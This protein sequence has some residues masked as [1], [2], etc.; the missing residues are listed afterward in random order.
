MDS[1]IS[2]N[3]VGVRI[4]SLSPSVREGLEKESSKDDFFSEGDKPI[5][6]G[7]FGQVWKVRHKTTGQIYVIKVMIKQNIIEQKMVGQINREVE[8]M[9]KIN[10]PHIIKLINHF[11]DDDYLY[12]IM[13]YASKGQ[14]YSLLK[15]QGRFDQRNAAQYMREV[16]S[17]VKYLHSFDPPIIHRDIK[18][19]NILLDENGRV[20]LADFGWSN[21]ANTNELR[22]TYCGTPEYLAPEMIRKEGHDT[23]IDI[24]DLGV[25]LFELLCGKPPFA[26]TSQNELFTNIKK[27]RINW[28]DDFPPLAKN[29]ISKILKQNPKERLTLDEILSHSWFDK[30][31]EI[32]PVLVCQ[33]IDER[34]WLES[35]MINLKNEKTK[36]EIN[37]ILNSKRKSIME[38]IRKMS[39]QNQKASQ[40]NTD[41]NPLRGDNNNSAVITQLNEQIEKLKKEN[42]D[43]KQKN[44][45]N[46]LKL[47]TLKNELSKIKDPSVKAQEEQKLQCL[48]DELDKYKRMNKDRLGFL[49]EIKEKGKEIMELKKK[50]QACE[51]DL[52][53]SKI[54]NLGLQKKYNE[55][56]AQNELLDVKLNGLKKQLDE[57]FKEKDEEITQYRKKYE[58]LKQKLLN[59]SSTEED[60]QFKSHT[61]LEMINESISEYKELFVKKTENLCT[62]LSDNKDNS[63]KLQTE[64]VN[65]LENKHQKVLETIKKTKSVLEQNFIQISANDKECSSKVNERLEWQKKQISAL[66][67]FK[68]KSINLETQVSKYEQTIK[69]KDEAFDIEK[70]RAETFEKL[71]KQ[72]LD[73]I[74]RKN[75]YIEHLEA[76]LGDVKDFIIRTFPE[77]LEDFNK[78]YNFP[79]C[80]IPK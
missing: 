25:L 42:S 73:D 55:E 50:L 9:Y 56:K 1:K 28:P 8:I 47:K 22:K 31:P 49:A 13:H 44:E 57:G 6:K 18:P 37:N 62:F 21:Y 70:K 23:S 27:Q 33:K 52:E 17:A 53:I 10:H 54:E 58:I 46:E 63:R 38:L 48:Q 2:T 67:P 72:Q 45:S 15:K 40:N 3:K 11:E 39:P 76:K 66:M 24:W 34:Q 75:K 30:N 64:L 79:S 14:L 68:I 61:L 51:K 71:N 35:H 59:E 29:L 74:T 69:T 65:I 4:L 36:E 78:W 77:K 16:I 26:G 41:D 43:L 5:G 19:E 7:G 32:K 60:S 12:L 20:K 80:P